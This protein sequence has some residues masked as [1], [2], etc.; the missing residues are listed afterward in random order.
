MKLS[1]YQIDAFTDEVFKGNSAAVVPLDSWLPDA[2][3]RK[4]LT[5]LQA[6]N[7]YLDQDV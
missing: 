4:K 2:I 5:P 3:S 6:A 1:T 7:L